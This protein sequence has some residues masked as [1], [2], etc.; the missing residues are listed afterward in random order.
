MQTAKDLEIAALREQ[1]EKEREKYRRL[2][3]LNCAQ[4]QEFDSAIS[5]KDGEIERLK[6][7]LD[8]NGPPTPRQFL[9]GVSSSDESKDSVPYHWRGTAPPV[10]MFS[11]KTRKS[12][13]MID[14]LLCSEQQNGTGGPNQRCSSNWRDT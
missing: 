14:S 10:E 7:V 4:L 3:S 2:W 1:L 9:P 13:W 12:A 11:D 8:S 5:V 6:S